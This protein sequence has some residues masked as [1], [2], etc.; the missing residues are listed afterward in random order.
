VSEPIISRAQLRDKGA[1]DFARGVPRNDHPFNWCSIGAIADWQQ[2]WDDA[3]ALAR[4]EHEQ[5]REAATV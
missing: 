1:A 4:V 3:A 2:G 5:A